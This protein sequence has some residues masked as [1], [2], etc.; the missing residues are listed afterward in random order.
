MQIHGTNHCFEYCIEFV[1][2]IIR[3]KEHKDSLGIARPKDHSAK[4]KYSLYFNKLYNISFLT[5][6]LWWGR[7]AS[8]RSCNAQWSFLTDVVVLLFYT[9]HIIRTRVVHHLIYACINILLLLFLL[10]SDVRWPPAACL[11]LFKQERVESRRA[12]ID[13]D[14]VLQ[15]R[16]PVLEMIIFTLFPRGNKCLF[17]AR[18]TG[19]SRRDWRARIIH[20]HAYGIRTVDVLCRYTYYITY[21]YSIYRGTSV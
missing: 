12:S 15:L 6:G 20:I 9:K 11:L 5:L 13:G 4:A 3:R 18:P 7:V 17:N 21:L 8:L 2:A 10:F 19:E 16:M 14:R 1:F